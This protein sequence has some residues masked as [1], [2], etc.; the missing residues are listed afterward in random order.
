MFINVFTFLSD[1]QPNL[2]IFLLWMIASLANFVTKLEIKKPYSQPCTM[3]NLVETYLVKCLVCLRYNLLT[4][5]SSS[6]LSAR[7]KYFSHPS[8]VILSLSN[9]TH[10][11]KTESANR[12]EPTNSNSPGLQPF[13]RRCS[14]KNCWATTSLLSQTGMLSLFFIQY[15]CTGPYTEHQWSCSK[16][17]GSAWSFL[18]F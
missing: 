11:S 7:S 14:A 5:M 15:S 1:M 10:K 18:K 6:A 2:A 17:V 9:S 4:S 13:K 12:W 8:L 3:D 16:S